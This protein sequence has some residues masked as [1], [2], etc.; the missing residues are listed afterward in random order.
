MQRFLKFFLGLMVTALGASVSLW[1]LAGLFVPDLSGRNIRQYTPEE[2]EA[3]KESRDVSFDPNDPKPFHHHPDIDYTLGEEAPW[4]PKAESPIL[5][6]LVQEGHLPP[7]A[8]RVGSEPCVMRGYDGIG[9]YGGTWLRVATSPNDISVIGWRM[10][11]ASLFRWSPLGY[12]IRPHLAKSI[13]ATADKKEFIFHLRRGVKWSDGHPFTA[14]DVI[15][16]WKHETLDKEVYGRIPDWM[17]TAGETGMIELLDDY[18]VKFTFPKTYGLFMEIIAANRGNGFANTPAHYLKQYHP[19]LGDEVLCKEKMEAYKLPSR[20]ALYRYIKHFQNPEHPRMWPWIYRKYKSNPPQVFVR[21]PY[22]WVVDEQGN[23]LPYVDRVQFDIQPVKML[24][25][26][27]M[28]GMITMQTRHLRYEN[29]TDFLSRQK[30]SGTRILHWYPASRSVW[31]IN[32]N[33]NRRIDPDDPATKWKA[34]YLSDRRFRQALSVSLDRKTM[35]RAEYNGQVEPSQVAPGPASPFHSEELAKA[36]TQHDLV[37]ANKTLDEIGLEKRDYEGFRKFPDGTRM[38]FYLDTCPFTGIGPA[39]F[40]MD[41]WAK[42]GVR[43]ILRDTARTLFYIRKNSMNFD[44]NV[45]SGESDYLPLVLPRYFVPHHTESFYAVGWGRWFMR[46]GYFGNPD[47]LTGNSVE[48]PK[49]HPVY[50]AMTHYVNALQKPTLNE[51]K[52]EFGKA[53]KIAAENTWN[54][55]ISEAPPQLV[56]TRQGFKN[57]PKNAL[58]GAIFYTPGN[59][60]IETY[61]FEKPNDSPG[62][63]R[64]TKESILKIT[65]RPGGGSKGAGEQSSN[66]AGRIIQ[67]L[68]LAVALCS[69]LMV[70][71]KHPYIGHRLAIMFPTIWIISVVTF[72]I[73]QLPPGDYLTDRVIQLSESGDEADLSQIDDLKTLFHFEE[74]QIKKYFRWMGLFWFTSFETSDRGLLQ[75]NLGRSM[76]S[77]QEV[78]SIVGDRVLLTFLISLG[79]ILFTWVTAIPIGIYSAVKQYSVGDY[80]LT[81]VGF[82]GMCVPAFLLAL[83][84]MTWAG[85][86]GLFSAEFAA[87]P[88]WDWPKVIDLLK[89][90]W[91]PVVVLGVGGT[92]AMIRVMRANLLDELKKPYVTTARARG[93]RPFKLLIKYPVRLAL[94]PFV[95][96]IGGLF[97]K[98][99]SGGAIVGMVLSLPTVGPLMLSALFSQ[100]M[101]LA[102]SMLII[103]SLLGVL[104]TLVSD[105]LLLFLDP[106]IRFEGGTR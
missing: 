88:E 56:V 40:V 103:L 96:G 63:I 68:F 23:Q 104:G 20:K 19:T 17:K 70:G 58:Y 92:A 39:Q 13:E 49:D 44:F 82:I 52:E 97:P 51:Q 27:A 29:Y 21:N 62:A 12:P 54:I 87:Q 95:S 15:Y 46:G 32:P 79:T 93:V 4:Y 61:Y 37:W 25:L 11:Y 73:I 60:G 89:H 90:I 41:D 35:I 47:A 8:E 55:N 45:W 105:L 30:E 6:E 86:S 81:F 94:N 98:L 77:T 78:N 38:T 43:T 16:G 64:E 65:P 85:V 36:F 10:S 33:N 9:K 76:E 53:L 7:V 50:K 101:Y 72:V 67:Y 31:V 42:V 5:T 84:L 57:V 14:E 75:G 3:A 66:V 18:R 71:F 2:I 74:A 99:V 59:A 102:G 28:N 22:Y 24:A 1:I 83:V 48:P 100:D 106:R 80:I 26:S 69:V 34:K 91:I